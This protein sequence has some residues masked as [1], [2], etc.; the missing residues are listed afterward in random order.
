VGEGK[1]DATP[2]IAY[3]DAGITID[4]GTSVAEV[5]KKINEIN[6]KIISSLKEIG[7]Q[8]SDIKTSNYSINP[9]YTYVNN[10]NKTDGYN[11]N[12]SIEITVRNTELASKVI[13][14]VTASGANQI[15]GSRFVVEKP[16]TYREEARNAAIKNAK[17]QADKIAK[18]LGIKLGK[19]INIVESSPDQNIVPVF[20]KM[21]ADSVGGGGGSANI[22]Q[23][24][25]TITSVVTLYFEKR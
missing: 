17:D 21:S 1:V 25:Q 11:G 15:N 10:E 13:E 19:V 7:I 23:G 16:E 5:Q 9:N 8:K 18:D 6:N 2:D 20:A 14:T 3:V 22:E 24:S 4:R 12:V